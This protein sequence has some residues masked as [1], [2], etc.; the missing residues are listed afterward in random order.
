[1]SITPRDESGW[2]IETYSAHNEALRMAQE[3]FEDERDRRYREVQAARDEAIQVK[4]QASQEALRLARAAQNYR[5]ER[6][7]KLRE[8]LNEERSHYVA[9]TE[10]RGLQDHFDQALASFQ[11]R[12]EAAHKPLADYV[13][14]QLGRDA[15]VT[16]STRIIYSIL[17]LAVAVIVASILFSEHINP[18]NKTPTVVTVTTERPSK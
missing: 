16:Q 2:T 4:E 8:Q 7:N 13:A 6:D 3:R 14:T 9:R 5:D 10:L 18:R 15:G 17:T 11:Q 1:M 12:Y